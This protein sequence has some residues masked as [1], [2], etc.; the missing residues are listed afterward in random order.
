M[1]KLASLVLPRKDGMEPNVLTDVIQVKSG[2]LLHKAVS[3]Q[4]VNFGMDMHA[5]S[6]QTVKLGALILNHVNAQFPQHG[7]ESLVLFVLEE[8]FTTMLPTNANAQVVNLTM[9]MFVQ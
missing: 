8:E 9:V 3:A 7:M 4:V 2:M 1:V 5:L 6:V